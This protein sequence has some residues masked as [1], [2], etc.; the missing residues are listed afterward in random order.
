MGRPS[1]QVEILA[2]VKRLTG[3]DTWL[4]ATLSGGRLS[5]GPRRHNSLPAVRPEIDCSTPALGVQGGSML[6]Q[7]GLS[8]SE[9]ERWMCE[10]GQGADMKPTCEALRSSLHSN[11]SWGRSSGSSATWIGDGVLGTSRL[12][13]SRMTKSEFPLAADECPERSGCTMGA[14]AQQAIT[15]QPCRV[16]QDVSFAQQRL[17]TFESQVRFVA[18]E[19][20]PQHSLCQ[21]IEGSL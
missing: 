9:V 11:T 19:C 20:A 7:F 17:H 3:V 13:T 15:A 14:P 16:H 10:N 5:P 1:N 6:A 4:Q 8:R 21:C 12:S 18:Q 2:G